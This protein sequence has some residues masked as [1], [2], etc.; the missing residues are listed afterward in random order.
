MLMDHLK[1][2]SEHPIFFNAK[3]NML[4]FF[5]HYII[6]IFF[7]IFSNIVYHDMNIRFFIMFY[8]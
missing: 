6:F 8:V 4:N 5:F 7:V 3:K 1:K 2:L